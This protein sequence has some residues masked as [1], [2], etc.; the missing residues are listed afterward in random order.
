MQ[1]ANGQNFKTRDD[2]IT[3]AASRAIRAL[4][5]LMSGIFPLCYSTT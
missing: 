5:V 3:Y 2:L 1:L 4:D